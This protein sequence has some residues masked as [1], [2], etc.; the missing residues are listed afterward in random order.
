MYQVV[1]RDDG[2]STDVSRYVG[3]LREPR[4]PG[5]FLLLRRGPVTRLP[6]VAMGAKHPSSFA[7][8]VE[9]AR[10]RL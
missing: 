9:D 2:C 10:T 1:H 7:E 8:P 6:N 5:P 3:S 4:A